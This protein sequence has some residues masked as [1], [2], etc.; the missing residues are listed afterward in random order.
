NG[1]VTTRRTPPI[2]QRAF[3]PPPRRKKGAKKPPGVSSNNR[4]ASYGGVIEYRGPSKAEGRRSLGSDDGAIVSSSPSYHRQQ[5]QQ[6]QQAF[7]PPP[8]PPPALVTS[9]PSTGSGN[10][11]STQHPRT[12]NSLLDYRP[13]NTSSRILS[14]GFNLINVS[15]RTQG[16]LTP[17]TR[18]GMKGPGGSGGD[19]N[20][21]SSQHWTASFGS[22]T[23]RGFIAGQQ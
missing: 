22:A 19:N 16:G 20:S 9:R 6:Q 7:T 11:S 2:E 3:H 13:S 14:S 12:A 23:G 15:T 21:S 10:G 17:R 18:E 4:R 5:Q 1:F 8:T